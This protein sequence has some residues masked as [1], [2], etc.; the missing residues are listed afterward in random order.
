MSS[1]LSRVIIS[2]ATAIAATGALAGATVQSAQAAAS[3]EYAAVG[4]SFAA[5]N[6]TRNPDLSLACSRSSDAYGPQIAAERA[7]TTL[8]F[9]ACG[10][11]VTGD[12]V[13]TQSKSLSAETDWVTISIGGNDIGFAELLLSCGSSFDEPSC[14][15]KVDEVNQRID[16]ELGAKLDAAYDSVKQGA[17]GATVIS[18]GYP[19]F[20]GADIS[21]PDADGISPN[22]ATA[23]N[24]LADNLEAEIADRSR[25]AGIQHINPI[26]QF[27]G[28]DICSSSPFLNGKAELSA[29]DAYHPSPEG[30]SNGFKPLIRKIMG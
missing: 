27:S 11:A 1:T 17:P 25:V 18:I 28:H 10:G 15:A 26:Q 8:V 30:Y 2:S 6:G 4:D 21:C 13:N 9:P 5:G 3:E 19:R 22:E 7:S 24:G 12:V 20:F 16:T 29:T 14:L 23:L